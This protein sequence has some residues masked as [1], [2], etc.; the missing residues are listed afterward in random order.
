MSRHVRS[1]EAGADGEDAAIA[2]AIP[3]FFETAKG[4]EAPLGRPRDEA[5]FE[6]ISRRYLDGASWLD[7]AAE[8]GYASEKAANNTFS[9]ALRKRGLRMVVRR[10]RAIE[11]LDGAS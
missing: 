2:P 11:P 5:R 1:P 3:D 7:I 8:F 6:A 10:A 4:I 9:V